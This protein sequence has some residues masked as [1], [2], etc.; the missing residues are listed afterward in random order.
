MK[1]LIAFLRN[2]YVV[3]RTDG[4]SAYR[5]GFAVHY[6]FSLAVTFFVMALAAHVGIS[7]LW[8]FI[9][10]FS[11][12]LLLWGVGVYVGV[13]SHYG[14]VPL[15]AVIVMIAAGFF[16]LKSVRAD[17]PFHVLAITGLFGSSMAQLLAQG[18]VWVLQRILRL[19]LPP[20]SENDASGEG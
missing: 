13:M 16:V 4:F 19:I 17:T 2:Y 12:I 15:L 5:T 7:I 18:C 1:P 20:E 9:T 6:G 14:P 8:T 10:A 11:L 3:P